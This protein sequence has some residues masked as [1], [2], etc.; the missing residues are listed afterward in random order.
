MPLSPVR[1]SCDT[2]TWQSVDQARN[3]HHPRSVLAA[4][5]AVCGGHT[6]KP[7]D[8]PNGLF[9]HNAKLR[10][11]PIVENILWGTVFAAWLPSRRKARASQFRQIQI[12]KS[13]PTPT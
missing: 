7:A 11:R 12:S 6:L 8:L 10:K 4:V 1:V 2:E 13:P 3:C 9:D 5:I